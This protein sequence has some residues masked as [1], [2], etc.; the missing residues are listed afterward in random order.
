MP[1]AGMQ[2]QRT[3]FSYADDYAV[4][5]MAAPGTN[6]PSRRACSL[7][8]RRTS[9]NKLK[10]IAGKD[11]SARYGRFSLIEARIFGSLKLCA[12]SNVYRSIFPPFVLF[13]VWFQ[14]R[15]EHVVVPLS[16]LFIVCRR[17]VG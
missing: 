14:G 4:A 16:V 12:I 9:A 11:S 8:S 5:R 1:W 10:S 6:C 17:L 3:N 13:L 7:C 2:F 15:G